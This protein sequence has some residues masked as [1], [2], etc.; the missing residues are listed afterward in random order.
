L[1]KTKVQLFLVVKK[2]NSTLSE[3]NY[4]KCESGESSLAF[5]TWP[6]SSFMSGMA[7]GVI[8]LY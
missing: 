2:D 7:F 8:C 5:A 4:E 6:F 1:G 3:E